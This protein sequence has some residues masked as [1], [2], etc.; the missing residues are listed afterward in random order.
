MYI[1]RETDYAVRIST[2][3]AA[4]KTRIGASKLSELNDI[5][6][7]FTLKILRKLMEGGIVKSYMGAKG[8]YELAKPA[9]EITLL[10]IIE[11]VEGTYCFSRCLHPDH[12]CSNHKERCACKPHKVYTDITNKVRKMLSEQTL[13]MLA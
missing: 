3:L 2:C 9:S 5:P 1:T 10:Q 8:G 11:T 4:Q 7:R 6:S 13:D 12:S